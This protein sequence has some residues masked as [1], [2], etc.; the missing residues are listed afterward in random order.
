MAIQLEKYIEMRIHFIRPHT[1]TNAT[2]SLTH[3]KLKLNLLFNR[4]NLFSIRIT[5]SFGIGAETAN[6]INESPYKFIETIFF[7]VEISCLTQDA[8]LEV[9]YV[10]LVPVCFI[11]SITINKSHANK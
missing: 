1:I 3:E 4:I 6:Q 5:R 8:S 9:Y 7:F 2:H 11:D 10:T